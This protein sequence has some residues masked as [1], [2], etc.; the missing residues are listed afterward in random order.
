MGEWTFIE[1]IKKLDT[2]HNGIDSHDLEKAVENAPEWLKW[3]LERLEGFGSCTC[4]FCYAFVV[5]QFFDF[6][7]W[8]TF[9]S[10]RQSHGL[11]CQLGNTYFNPGHPEEY[12]ESDDI[13]QATPLSPFGYAISLCTIM[14]TLLVY[15]L[16]HVFHLETRAKHLTALAEG[17]HSTTEQRDAIRPDHA[18]AV[19]AA[20]MVRDIEV[21]AC[22]VVAGL[23]WEPFF[24]A[25]AALIAAKNKTE[26]E[27][28]GPASENMKTK[29]TVTTLVAVI[30]V[31]FLHLSLWICTCFFG[32]Y[33]EEEEEE[34]GEKK[35][36]A[37]VANMELQV[38]A[39][40]SI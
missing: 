8:E 33:E 35:V 12:E 29:A 3:M 5:S 4:K 17:E 20:W 38:E 22:G 6:A 7:F 23:A 11:F 9:M 19:R 32:F 13:F 15:H 21:P 10:G 1:A 40:I 34:D 24:V 31:V 30:Y 26:G 18:A 36:P 16:I 37:V 25:I 14:I 2:D 28:C 27:G 39:A